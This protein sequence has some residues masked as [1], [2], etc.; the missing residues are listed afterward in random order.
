MGFITASQHK[1]IDDTMSNKA[2]LDFED[3]DEELKRDC[4]TAR[5]RCT[6]A[7]PFVCGFLL[8]KSRNLFDQEEVLFLQFKQPS[9]CLE[10]ARD[11]NSK[12]F[13]LTHRNKFFQ[14]S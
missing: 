14:V 1:N 11:I 6:K 12:I 8:P 2:L 7:N 9:E 4:L 13:F 5:K 3:L 10:F